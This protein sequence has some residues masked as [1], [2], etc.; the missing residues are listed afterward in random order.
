MKTTMSISTLVALLSI[1][2]ST[3]SAGCFSGGDTWPDKANA[4][5]HAERACRGFDGHG[6][7]F[8]GN[9]APFETKTACVG[10]SSTIKFNMAVQNLNSQ[11]RDV[12]DDECVLRLHNEINGCDRGGESQIGDWF[13]RSDPNNGNC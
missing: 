6:G 1:G 11:T 3:V 10:L 8:S 12:S 7:A 9:F 4:R 13:F 5:W 2:V